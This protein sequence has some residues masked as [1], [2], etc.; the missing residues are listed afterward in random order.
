MIG[1]P[2]GLIESSLV[3]LIREGARRWAMPDAFDVVTIERGQLGESVG[4]LGAACQVLDRKLQ[5]ALQA[6][7][8]AQD[9][10]SAVGVPH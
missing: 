6:I 8:C 3:D 4:A 5:L 7:A 2:V 9:S 10:P 1:G